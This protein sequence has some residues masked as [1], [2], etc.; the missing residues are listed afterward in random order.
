MKS[1][2][3]SKI[4]LKVTELVEIYNH[5]PKALLGKIIK[6]AVAEDRELSRSS[7]LFLE[8]KRNG[9]YWLITTEDGD[10]WLFPK[11]NLK[12][13][14]FNQTTVKSLFEC[15][16]NEQTEN[17]EFIVIKPAQISLMP[18]GKLWKLAGK[19]FLNFDS[20]AHKSQLQ[21]ELDCLKEEY[22]QSQ[23]KI[24]ELETERSR[25]TSQV[26]KLAS[27]GLENIQ[28]EFVL[29]SEFEEKVA[30][31]NNKKL[32]IEQIQAVIISPL[33]Q[34]I[35]K[36]VQNLN[37]KISDLANKMGRLETDT[38]K[39]LT[40]EIITQQK[41]ISTI[42]GYPQLISRIFNP[43]SKLKS[44]S[45]G[46]SYKTVI[47]S[48]EEY[49]LARKYNQNPKTFADV[50]IKVNTT[51]DSINYSRAGSNQQ[52]VLV[53]GERNNYWIIQE[54][55]YQYLVPKA[56]LKINH[57]NYQ[58]ATILFECRGYEQSESK[59]FELL[60]PAKVISGSTPEEWILQSTGVLEFK[61]DIKPS[62]SKKLQFEINKIKDQIDNEKSKK[63]T[64]NNQI[65]RQIIFDFDEPD[66]PG[67]VEK[68]NLNAASLKLTAIPVLVT[69][70]SINETR[71]GGQQKMILQKTRRG[72]Y[73]IVND[74]EKNYLVPESKFKI[75]TFNFNDTIALFE[76]N[77]YEASSSRN[78]RLIQPA[79]VSVV[80][81]NEV[82]QL[83][84]RGILQFE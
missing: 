5:A 67:I 80:T 74:S 23:L 26:A 8:A 45:T 38:R 6:V 9:N 25:L 54:G 66:K 13:N 11:S 32:G 48:L 35:E 29:R 62:Q 1:E 28:S 65:N 47:P 16:G 19:G 10:I 56:N 3:N 61:A 63:Q 75:N 17:R 22:E 83:E 2:Q 64:I 27:E 82:W 50:A 24:E 36:I 58:T 42:E 68:Y 69:E 14:S 84:E 44:S 73:W 7:N 59:E 12:I 57:F 43:D 40:T 81:S 70:K 46:K 79:R 53:T 55:S 39:E 71:S 4:N 78:F 52:V 77:N 15:Q 31:L 60:Q 21:L 37:S 41:K 34:D 72:N 76:C 20:D 30:Y 49:N 18:S 51:E 33:Q